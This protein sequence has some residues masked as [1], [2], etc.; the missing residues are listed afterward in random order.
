[1]L[2]GVYEEHAEMFVEPKE[3]L[4]HYR[5][6]LLFGNSTS[7]SNVQV[8]FFDNV[9]CLETQ[10]IRHV[11]SAWIKVRRRNNI[12]QTYCTVKT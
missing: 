1:M 4:R 11:V 6:S 12:H 2:I 8:F 10:V 7:L 9:E 5:M 3:I